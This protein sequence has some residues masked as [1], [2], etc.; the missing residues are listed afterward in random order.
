[1][2]LLLLLLLLLLFLLLLLLLNILLLL[3][4][5]L[6]GF[7]SSRP[8]RQDDISRGLSRRSAPHNLLQPQLPARRWPLLLLLWLWLPRLLLLLLLLLWL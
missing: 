7:S 5:W 2:L 4:H 1:M 8:G 3:G 6:L